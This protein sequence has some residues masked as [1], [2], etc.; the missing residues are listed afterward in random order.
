MLPQE[1]ALLGEDQILFLLT[2]PTARDEKTPPAV[3]FQRSDL[4]AVQKRKILYDNPIHL[5]G[6]L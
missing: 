1:I 2:F 6:A 4:T 3:F 5:F